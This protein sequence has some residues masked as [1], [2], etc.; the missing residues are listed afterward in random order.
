MESAGLYAQCRRA[1]D[2]EGG[3]RRAVPIAALLALLLSGAAAAKVVSYTLPD[4]PEVVLPPGAG[5][6]LVATQ[7][8]ACHSLDYIQTQPYK[9]GKAFWD[10]TVTKMVK[11]Y[12]APVTPE[13]GE[14][15]SAYLAEH[16]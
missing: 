11:I 10:A 6:D 15:I 8:A 2:G 12:G 9:K 4:E 1:R 7:C 13:D 3:M 14:A 5:A 16:Y